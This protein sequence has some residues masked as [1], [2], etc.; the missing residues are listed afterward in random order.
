MP[1]A[2]RKAWTGLLALLC[3]LALLAGAEAAAGT[4][5][6]GDQGDE[7]M[8]LQIALNQLGYSTGGTDG[9]YGTRTENAVRKFQKAN[10]LNVDGLAG[11]RTQTLIY[12][13][14]GTAAAPAATPKPQAAA[15]PAAQP[16]AAAAG[17]VFGGNYTKMQLGSKGERVTLLQQCL[18]QLGYTPGKADGSFGNATYKAVV[19][20]QK[21]EGLTKDGVAGRK[22]LTRIE[23]RLT[24]GEAAPAAPAAT[25]APA[26]TAAPAPAEPAAAEGYTVP[27]ATL[28]K[29]AT[30]A[31]V[32]S[33][34]QRLK[35][36]GYYTGKLDGSYGN[37]TMNAVRAF[38]KKNGLGQDGL[39]GRMTSAKLFSSSALAADAQGGGTEA[40]STSGKMSSPSK[41]S[42]K[43][44][45]W[46]NDVKPN[47]KGGQTILVFDPSTSQCWTL[48]LLSLGRHADAEPLTAADTASMLKAFGGVNTWNQK[49]VYV[50]LPGGTWTVASTHDMPHDSGHIKDNNFDGHLCVHFLRDMD[51]CEKNDPKYGVSNQKTIRAA[52]KALTGETVK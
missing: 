36:L 7:V 11:T 39:V 10:G 4:L 37:G 26:P 16:A 27:T 28:R 9:K 13:K 33:V 35:E 38:Q 23:S 24:S 43:L 44:L 17:S 31:A 32:L 29:G 25:P 34:Q 1:M 30:G 5:R 2:G 42:I 50:R 40:A 14:V 52:W 6:N 46:F 47:M 49:A 48:R 51:E 45:H 20:F 12:Q 18:A 15:A 22:T 3:C 8:N 21:S 41:S 19:A